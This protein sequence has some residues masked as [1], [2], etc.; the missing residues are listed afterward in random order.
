MDLS[1]NFD[2]FLIFKI[3]TQFHIQKLIFFLYFKLS[4]SNLQII[5]K[6]LKPKPKTQILKN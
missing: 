2:F 1:I 3:Y 6:I 4:Y 5:C